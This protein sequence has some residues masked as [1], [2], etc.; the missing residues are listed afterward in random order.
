MTKEEFEALLKRYEL[1]TCTEDEWN[2]ILQYCNEMER[3]G[4]PPDWKLGEEEQARLKILSAINRQI[5]TLEDTTS[6]THLRKSK[7]ILNWVWGVAASLIL[8]S[9]FIFWITQDSTSPKQETSLVSITKKAERGQKL[10]LKLPDGSEV[11]LN[12]ESSVTYPSDF[13]NTTLREVELIGEGFFNVTEDQQKPFV[14]KTGQINTQVLGTTFN[15]SA[16]PDEPSVSVT[17]ETGKVKV[18]TSPK[19]GLKRTIEI[20]PGEQVN[21]NKSTREMHKNKV[22]LTKYLGWTEGTLILEEHTLEETAKIL[23]RWYNVSFEFTQEELKTCRLSG[24]FKSDNLQNILKNIQFLTNLQFSIIQNKHVV[25]KGE[26][27]K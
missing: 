19:E 25:V 2:I 20:N 24:E 8:I 23:S 12:A 27:C 4:T 3:K 14:V 17:L 6:T 13:T 11:K 1:G 7:P 18:E 22:N 21:F 5:D 15:V 10:T 9:G 26:S 16:Y